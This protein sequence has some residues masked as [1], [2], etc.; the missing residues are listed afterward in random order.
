MLMCHCSKSMCRS[1][2][3]TNKNTD[4]TRKAL[5]IIPSN[6]VLQVK[7]QHK[8]TQRS[9]NA[10][11][12]CPERNKWV[13]RISNT[14]INPKWRIRVPCDHLLYLVTRT[15]S[16]LA[17]WHVAEINYELVRCAI[18][19]YILNMTQYAWAKTTLLYM[20]IIAKYDCQHMSCYK[21]HYTKS[22]LDLTNTCK[23][24]S[25]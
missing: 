10:D 4:T 9:R 17:E 21:R 23:D 8:W 18:R 2:L 12:A 13:L 24:N 25:A 3:N 11:N 5:A 6:S 15:S 22:H 19:P 1:S 20:P 7:S 16:K 14:N